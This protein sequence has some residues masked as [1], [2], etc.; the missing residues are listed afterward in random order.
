MKNVLVITIGNSDI[1][2]N[3]Y[4][5]HGFV[6]EDLILKKESCGEIKLRP[7]RNYNDYYLLL[8]SRNDG[9]V[10]SKSYD[11]YKEILEFPLI[12]PL[13]TYFKKENKSFQEVWWVYTDQQKEVDHFQS[14]DTLYYKQ[15]IQKYFESNYQGVFYKDY[16]ITE[17]V[18]DI[19]AQYIDFYS[20]ALALINNTEPI[21]NIFLLPQGGIDQI[22]QALTLQLIQ[23]FKDKVHVFQ[24][25]E[26]SEVVELMFPHLFLKD[27]TKK[28]RIKHLLDYDFDKA[29]AISMSEDDDWI[30]RLCKYATLRLNMKALE[31]FQLYNN[32]SKKEQEGLGED[33][34][35]E[36]KK[37]WPKL[38]F[39]DQNRIKLSDLIIHCKILVFQKKN[40][41]FLIKLFT[42]IENFFKIQLET[43]L[44]I[45]KDTLKEYF[46]GSLQSNDLNIKWENFINSLHP[47][48]L[49]Y[50]IGEKT[51]LNNPNR[52][53][54]WLIYKYLLNNGTIKND[55]S[56]A[57]LE[58]FNA[59]IE[60]LTKRRNGII[61]GLKGIS[62]AEMKGIFVSNNTTVEYIF[63]I[64]E[65]MNGINDFGV[66]R[67]IQQKILAYY[68]Q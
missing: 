26:K 28:T 47:S 49:S 13:L 55:L 58:K 3:K 43:C 65:T 36:I 57:E 20:K 39:N 24:C 52:K 62:D 32:I 41:E 17:N 63:K 50:L 22:N 34:L 51:W 61:H 42:I 30:V 1:Q 46:N 56:I 9:F 4:P 27:L 15:I 40:N 54:Y 66:F 12:E 45:E 10:I 64:L 2:I 37:D 18:K 60:N 44:S 53:S 59:I 11:Q 38:S 48:L 14:G 29:G 31:A 7:N 19:D 6:I 21:S 67:S 5:G 16:P 25:A 68:G 33:L 8:S 23:L 35:K